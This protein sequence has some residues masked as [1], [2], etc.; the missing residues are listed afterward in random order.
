MWEVTGVV[1]ALCNVRGVAD[2]LHI[3]RVI[4]VFGTEARIVDVDDR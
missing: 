2:H 3:I 1:R 4:P